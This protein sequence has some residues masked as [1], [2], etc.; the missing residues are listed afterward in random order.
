MDQK[1]HSF[2]P[3]VTKVKVCVWVI[4]K[5]ERERASERE[6]EREKERNKEKDKET[7]KEG[8]IDTLID[9]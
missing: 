1:F 2:E 5:R 7:E 3:A 9:K 6:R 8:R 4:L